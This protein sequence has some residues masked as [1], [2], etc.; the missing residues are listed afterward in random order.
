[1]YTQSDSTGG[2][3]DLTLWRILKL[4]H[5]GAAPY[6][7]ESDIYDYF[8]LN[9]VTTGALLVNKLEATGMVIT[10]RWPLENN[11]DVWRAQVLHAEI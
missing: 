7:G 8:A 1:V 10:A 4:T 2:S 6:G 11:L 3:T 9:V 5:R